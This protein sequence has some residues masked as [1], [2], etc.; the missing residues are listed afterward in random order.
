LVLDQIEGLE[1][2]ES[3]PSLNLHVRTAFLDEKASACHAIG[4]FAEQVGAAFVPYPK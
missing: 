2:D 4:V 3:D 1:E